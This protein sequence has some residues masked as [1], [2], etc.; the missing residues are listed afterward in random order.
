LQWYAL[1]CPVCGFRFPIKKFSSKMKPII[2]PVQ[3]VSGGGRAKGFKVMKYLPWSML[4]TLQQTDAWVSVLCL[5]QRLGSAYDRFYEVLGF[6][7]PEMK[8]LLQELQR[9]YG[10]SYST[11]LF[12]D[13]GQVYSPTDSS[14]KIADAYPAADYSEVYSRAL[15]HRVERG[16]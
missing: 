4:A 13:Y 9:P 6:L 10:G 8:K 5:Y 15:T 12:P 7:S 11:S 3:I 14:E 1:T 2:Y 16:G